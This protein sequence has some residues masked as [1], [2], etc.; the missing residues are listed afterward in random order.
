LGLWET[1]GVVS[2]D[3]TAAPATGGTMTYTDILDNSSTVY[4]YRVLANNVIGDTWDYSDPNLN[5][6]ASFPTLSVDSGFSNIASVQSTAF[7]I[8]P[9]LFKTP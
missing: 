7:T 5:N 9:L 6:G 2:L 8:I 3:I 4:Y 1:V